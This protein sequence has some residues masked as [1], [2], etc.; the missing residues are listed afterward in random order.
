VAAGLAMKVKAEVEEI[1]SD[2]EFGYLIECVCCT[3]SRCHHYEMTFGLGPSSIDRCL[4]QLRANCPRNEYN[5]YE[6]E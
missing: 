5:R 3:C 1:E 2:N 6:A 4:A